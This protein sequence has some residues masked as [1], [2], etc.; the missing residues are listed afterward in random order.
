[1]A[2]VDHQIED[3]IAPSWSRPNWSPLVVDDLTAAL[4][5][6]QM[7]VEIKKAAAKT[8]APVA[9]ADLIKAAMVNVQDKVATQRTATA[10]SRVDLGLTAT[11]GEAQSVPASDVWSQDN[12]LLPWYDQPDWADRLGRMRHERQLNATDD[13]ML[14]KWCEEGYVVIPGLVA[15]DLIDAL[16][17]EVDDMWERSVPIEGLAVSALEL[18]DGHKA[19]LPHSELV[20]IRC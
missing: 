16:V 1:M 15:A 9:E 2:F 20:R 17:A 14:R 19:H 12:A 6:T 5:P 11:K 13:A 10:A 3:R 7:A 8:G 18:D 4:D